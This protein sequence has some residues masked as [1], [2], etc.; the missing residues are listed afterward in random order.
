MVF[1]VQAFEVKQVLQTQCQLCQLALGFPEQKSHR[2]CM[3]GLIFLCGLRLFHGDLGWCAHLR[4]ALEHRG[5]WKTVGRKT[6]VFLKG[7]QCAT[8]AV[9][10][11]TVGLAGVIT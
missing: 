5:R 3:V 7:A 6:L 1:A 9:A 10:G 8:G 2:L 4:Q 11:D